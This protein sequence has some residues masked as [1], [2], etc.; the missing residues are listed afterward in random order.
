MPFCPRRLYWRRLQLALHAFQSSSAAAVPHA[1]FIMAGE[2]RGLLP[3]VRKE[4][5]QAGLESRLVLIP[6]TQEPE[7]LYPAM[8]AYICTSET[9]GFSNVLLEGAASG[10]PLIATSVGG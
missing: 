3:A 6:G 10:L 9:E 8:D 2:D 5:A 4:I 7:K 1:R